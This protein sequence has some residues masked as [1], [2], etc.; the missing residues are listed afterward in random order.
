MVYNVIIL[1]VGPCAVILRLQ[2]LKPVLC[3]CPLC[4]WLCSSDASVEREA[5][6]HFVEDRIETLERV[7][8]DPRL[9]VPHLPNHE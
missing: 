8:A 5:I 7:C 1:A 9:Q 4:L 3:L 2:P 6:V